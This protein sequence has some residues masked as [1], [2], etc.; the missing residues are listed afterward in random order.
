MRA[1]MLIGDRIIFMARHQESDTVWASEHC[2]AEEEE[3]E[4]GRMETNNICDGP[5]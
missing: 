3:E 5:S 4:G 1:G 2:A